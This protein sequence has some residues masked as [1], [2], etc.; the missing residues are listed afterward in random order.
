[1]TQAVDLRHREMLDMIPRFYDDAPEADGI[2]HADAIE[3]ERVRKDARDLLA[4]LSATTASWGLSDWERVLDLPP[5]PNSSADLRRAR[6]L[7]KLRG[8]APA[9]LANMLAIINAHVPQQDA[10]IVE[11][12]EPGTFIVDIPLQ[13]DISLTGLVADLNVFKPAHLAYEIYGTIAD[14]LRISERFYSFEIANL[15][16]NEFTTDD[17]YGIGV[18]TRISAS[19]RGYEFDVDY[20]VTNVLSTQD[21]RGIGVIAKS[22]EVQTQNY[23]VSNPYLLCGDFYAEEEH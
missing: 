18:L 9:T 7:A 8:T 17:S 19:G 22:I 20:P 4:Q 6:I 23:D 1:M 13:S 3:I 10:N 12:L 14:V 5:R 16:C 11:L 21:A 2:L 15:I